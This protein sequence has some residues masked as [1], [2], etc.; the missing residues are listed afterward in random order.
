[1]AAAVAMTLAAAVIQW[2]C[3]MQNNFRAIMLAD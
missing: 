1:M 2:F 3:V